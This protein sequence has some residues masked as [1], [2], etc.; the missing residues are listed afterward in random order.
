MKTINLRNVFPDLKRDCYIE[1]PADQYKTYVANLT[2]EIADV[3]IQFEREEEA[4]KRKRSRY[5]AFYSLDCGD[6]IE[7]HT[8]NPIPIP[9]Q[10]IELEHDNQLLYSALSLLPKPQARRIYKHY[11]LQQS[12]AEIAQ[13]ENVT[14]QN[15]GKSI[16]RALT[17]LKKSIQFSEQGLLLP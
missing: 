3:Y 1:V 16:A 5:G 11:V 8:L 4:R 9:E 13:N 17:A 15:V 12:K 7:K 14:K 6:G 2:R 10:I